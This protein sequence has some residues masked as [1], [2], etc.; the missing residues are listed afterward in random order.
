[1]QKEGVRR[2]FRSSLEASARSPSARAK[3]EVLVKTT[4]RKHGYPPDLQGEATKTVL[5]QAELLCHGWAEEPA[6]KREDS[7]RSELLPL[8][9]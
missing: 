4:L 2:P 1:M 3:S 5:G 8:R 7:R 9:L 6:V